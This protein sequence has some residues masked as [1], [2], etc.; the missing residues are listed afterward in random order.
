MDL[1]A[2]FGRGFGKSNL[3]QMRG[4]YLSYSDIFQTVSG[5]SETAVGGGMFQTAS[6]ISEAPSPESSLSQLAPAFPLP[7]SHYVRLLSVSSPEAR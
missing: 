1:T 4:F 3:F 2:R 5:K 7:W 6:E